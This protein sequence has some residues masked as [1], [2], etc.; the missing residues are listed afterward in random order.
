MPRFPPQA[1]WELNNGENDP[2]I[3]VQWT[4]QFTGELA[5]TD[6]YQIDR[7]DGT[8]ELDPNGN[9]IMIEPLTSGL[10]NL[11]NKYD[12]VPQEDGNGPI[13]Y[14]LDRV[15]FACIKDYFE[16]TGGNPN[17]TRGPSLPLA[18]GMAV[19]CAVIPWWGDINFSRR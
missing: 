16:F 11:N 13:H 6:P 9:P 12:V 7:C 18:K 2:Q 10:N 3:F 4:D 5:P 15:E 17:P 14:P 19:Q 1:A 8:F